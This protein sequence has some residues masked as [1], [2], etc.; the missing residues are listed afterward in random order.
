M[1]PALNGSLAVQ[2]F[3]RSNAIKIRDRIIF[4]FH[5]GLSH[6]WQSR[7]EIEDYSVVYFNRVTVFKA[8]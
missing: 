5:T 4:D 3:K 6:M 2:H 7:V 8:L 1:S